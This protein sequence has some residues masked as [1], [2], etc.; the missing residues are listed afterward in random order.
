MPK[1]T[2]TSKVTG[3]FN[4]TYTARD[5]KNRKIKGE[6]LSENITMAQS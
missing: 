2:S 5:F 4:F 3:K 6:I 1:P